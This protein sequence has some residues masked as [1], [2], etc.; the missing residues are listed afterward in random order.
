[1]VSVLMWVDVS[2]GPVSIG[3]NLLDNEIG[4][5]ISVFCLVWIFPFL[6]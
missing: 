5:F 4:S 6:Y 2:T 3:L 1:M